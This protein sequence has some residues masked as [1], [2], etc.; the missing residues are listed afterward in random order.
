MIH[1]DRAT[2]PA[3]APLAL[4]APSALA[5]LEKFFERDLERRGQKTPKFDVSLWTLPEVTGA[6]RKLFR[7]KCAFCEARLQRGE[8]EAEHFRPKIHATEINGRV[9][10][11]HYWWLAYD[12][13]NL[14]AICRECQRARG[15]RFPVERK[16]ATPKST[17]TQLDDEH[18]LLLDP[19]RDP[20]PEQS[21]DFRE[22]EPSWVSIPAAW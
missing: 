6:L 2:V 14:Y 20:H 7:G 11:D 5:D 15:T 8:L 9:D 18:A 4:R 19:C 17:G 22:M 1:V 12:W 3:P 16:R 10:P 13:D 21:L